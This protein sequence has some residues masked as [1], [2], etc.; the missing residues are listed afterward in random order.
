MSWIT[1]RDARF[2]LLRT[3]SGWKCVTASFGTQEGAF[4]FT[5]QHCHQWARTPRVAFCVALEQTQGA[6]QVI[7][8]VIYTLLYELWSICYTFLTYFSFSRILMP[9]QRDFSA[10]GQLKVQT[11]LSTL[12]K[13]LLVMLPVPPCRHNTHDI[14]ARNII[15]SRNRDLQAAPFPTSC[16]VQSQYKMT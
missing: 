12:L 9:V 1:L 2:S 16:D 13:Q 8:G 14:E 15:A 4:W 5:E 11:F 3:S 10:P 7:R 6:G